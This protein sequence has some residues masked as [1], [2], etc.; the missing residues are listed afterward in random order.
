LLNGLSLATGG[1]IV[2]T[3]SVLTAFGK[4]QKQ[5]TDAISE[6]FWTKTGDDIRNNNTGNVEMKMNDSKQVSFLNFNNTLQSRIT[7]DGSYQIF[8]NGG[9]FGNGAGCIITFANRV[10]NFASYADGL[11]RYIFNPIY[12][13]NTT[14]I[15]DVIGFQNKTINPTSGNAVFNF[16]DID[17]IINQSGGANGITRAIYINPTLTSAADFRA[18]EITGGKV[19]IPNATASNE[20]VNLGQIS[21]RIAYKSKATYALMVADDTPTVPTIYSIT[22]DENKSYERSTYLWKPDGNREWI[23]TTPD[24]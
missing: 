7:E 14:G 8:G 6:L 10:F 1:A 16:L 11:G 17:P 21:D 4:L 22:N 23:A 24:N 2:S 9:I 5:I 20:A 13:S 12:L 15:V 18:L 19:I 3:D